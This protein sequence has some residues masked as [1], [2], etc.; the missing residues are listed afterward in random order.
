MQKTTLSFAC[1]LLSSFQSFSA[2]SNPASQA[3][4]NTVVQNAVD[5]FTAGN[6]ILITGTTISTTPFLSV[7]DLYQGG[8]VFYVD[9]TG[10]HGL[11]VALTDQSTG[12]SLSEEE[13][14]VYAT[15]TGIG[16]GVINTTN[17]LATLQAA[18]DTQP[19]ATYVANNVAVTS[20]GLT[21]CL[22]PTTSFTD[23]C[24]G[25]WYLGSAYELQL[26]SSNFSTI[27]AAISA[28]S[29]TA[30][31]STNVYWTSTYNVPGSLS[32]V[33][34]YNVVLGTGV[35][36]PRPASDPKYV[37]AIRQF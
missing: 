12:I 25:G 37:R 33:Q 18:S 35:V 2:P 3:Y 4:V 36:D 15:A 10:R 29:G 7:G 21:S 17:I 23:S 26:I 34:A 32:A 9:D 16:A 31:V 28:N 22:T 30:I 19:N 6:G 20:D 8:V 1:L 14:Y 27:N 13:T 11:A 24:F 5:S